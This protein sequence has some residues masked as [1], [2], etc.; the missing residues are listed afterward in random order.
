MITG[1]QI[2]LSIAPDEKG[3]NGFIKVTP[4]WRHCARIV[5]KDSNTNLINKSH[6]VEKLYKNYFHDLFV[7]DDKF[8]TVQVS[9][10][11]KKEAS[12]QDKVSENGTKD[13]GPFVIKLNRETR[14]GSLINIKARSKKTTFFKTVDVLDDICMRTEK[15][16]GDMVEDESRIESSDNTKAFSEKTTRSNSKC[17]GGKIPN[18]VEQGC[19]KKESV[20]LHGEESESLKGLCTNTII[21]FAETL[22]I[23]ILFDVSPADEL[24]MMLEAESEKATLPVGVDLNLKNVANECRTVNLQHRTNYEFSLVNTLRKFLIF[25]HFWNMLLLLSMMIPVISQSIPLSSVTNFDIQSSL[26]SA[27]YW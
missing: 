1:N 13:M 18:K 27:L 12:K 5:R 16:M 17:D 4:N 2:L 24:L 8:Y 10:E 14:K 3:D 11:D 23:D 9:D 6:A 15:S 7:E 19:C 20:L 25:H 22:V 21:C 26:V